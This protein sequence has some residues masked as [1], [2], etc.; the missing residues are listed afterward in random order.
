MKRI[1]LKV[2]DFK[3]QSAFNKEK[4]ISEHIDGDISRLIKYDLIGKIAS[5]TNITRATIIE[6]LSN[7]E[8]VKFDLLK[9]NPEDFFIKISKI[10]NDEKAEIIHENIIYHKTNEKI[11]I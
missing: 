3:K 7:I 11:P 9:Q 10:I 2:E 8:K 6:I 4:T 1:G 5:E